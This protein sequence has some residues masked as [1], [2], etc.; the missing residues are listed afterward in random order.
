MAIEFKCACA[1]RYRVGEQYAGRKTKCPNC[2]RTLTIPAKPSVAPDNQWY[3][4]ISDL[5]QGPFS[6]T[7]LKSLVTDGK[8]LP[9]QLVRRGAGGKWVPA[10]SVKNLFARPKSLPPANRRV[11]QAELLAEGFPST[12]A[13]P[14][15][16]PR[17]VPAE[18]PR[19]GAT[20]RRILIKEEA[21]AKTVCVSCHPTHGV[22]PAC[23]GKLPT[24][25]AQQ[26]LHCK[27]SW[28]HGVGQRPPSAER[29]R[30]SSRAAPAA[31]SA[32]A[33]LMAKAVAESTAIDK[34]M[35]TKILR[36]LKKH[37]PQDGLFVA[38]DIPVKKLNAAR[39]SCRVPS[40]EQILGL[41]DCTTLGS[42][43]NCLLLGRHAA[44]FHNAWSGKS[45]GA[46]TIPYEDFCHRSFGDGG[47]Q[48]VSL[49]RNQHLNISGCSLSKTKLIDLL[50]S[51]KQAI[52]GR[53]EEPSQGASSK[54][55]EEGE[56]VGQK[57]AGG[58]FEFIIET[59]L[60]G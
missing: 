27:A 5:E 54:K 13:K 15:P 24:P 21:T 2:G 1:R 31:A 12:S 14:P 56:S 42:A 57:I 35:D 29:Q 33:I 18:C 17:R 46:G 20:L 23:G 45:S 30:F 48:E 9:Q 51:V 26:C 11:L 47:F 43:K 60:G 44:Y 49:D 22:C 10:G 59:M 38:P 58:F 7:E 40:S 55:K 39:R 50:R 41:I 36:A 37:L 4:K 32:D 52:T 53:S 34:P 19:C 6:S 28:R 25:Q 8:L 16:R 3:C